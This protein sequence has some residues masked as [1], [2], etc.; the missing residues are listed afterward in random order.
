MDNDELIE[1]NP[2]FK[3]V[4]EQGGFYSDDLMGV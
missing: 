2:I 1:V 3:A 4:S